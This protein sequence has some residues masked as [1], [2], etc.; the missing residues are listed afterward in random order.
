MKDLGAFVLARGVLHRQEQYG[1]LP[2]SQVAV[3]SLGQE[4]LHLDFGPDSLS[5]VAEQLDCAEAV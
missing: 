4:I 1:G 2:F 5:L 3:L